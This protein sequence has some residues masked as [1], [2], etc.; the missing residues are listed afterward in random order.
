ML[1]GAKIG[2]VNDRYGKKWIFYYDK[3]EASWVR[4]KP[5]ILR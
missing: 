3:N 2:E 4:S 5:I 1:T